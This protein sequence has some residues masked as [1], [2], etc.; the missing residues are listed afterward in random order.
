VK[1][2]VA[3]F[4][5]SV[6]L[7]HVVLLH[8]QAPGR[9]EYACTPD[10]IESFG[11]GCTDEDPCPV[12]LD[13]SSV[14]GSGAR[15]LLSGNLHTAN[16]T[17]YSVLLMSEDGGKTWTEPYKRVR[18][19]ALEQIQF[20][21]FEH[22]WI[23]GQIIDPLAKD[24]FFLL[25]TDGGKTWRQ[26][27]LFEDSVF[28]TLSQFWFDSPTHGELVFD[29]SVGNAK[30]YDLYETTTGGE[31]WSPTQSGSTPIHLKNAPAKPDAIFRVRTDA[32]TKT[33][34]IERRGAS[35]WEL[36]AGFLVHVAD[37]Q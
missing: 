20:F 11:L 15:L 14:Q 35:N 7:L 10:D 6:V 33:F 16:T 19:A 12:F 2:V 8:A 30:K 22:G 34:R 36:V 37:C 24:P 13:L 3:A 29:R 25:T 4:A 21:D 32:A 17:L 28:G 23:G 18:S 9:V 5:L 1:A 26:S 27:E 31:S